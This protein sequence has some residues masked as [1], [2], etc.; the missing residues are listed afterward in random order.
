MPG[1]IIDWTYGDQEAWAFQVR[2]DRSHDATQIAPL[3]TEIFA[4]MNLMIFGGLDDGGWT[5]TTGPA[6]C[7]CPSF[8]GTGTN[9]YVIMGPG[10]GIPWSWCISSNNASFDSVSGTV[11]GVTGTSADV[12]AAFASSINAAAG[13]CLGPILSSAAPI[14]TP[15]FAGSLQIY[16]NGHTN[17]TLEVGPAGTPCGDSAMCAVILSDAPCSFNPTIQQVALTN[18]DCNENNIDDAV[19]IATGASADNNGNGI[20]DDCEVLCLADIDGSGVVDV[21]DLIAVISS[22]GPC[23]GCPADTNGDQVVDVLDLVAVITSWGQCH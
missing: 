18:E 16:M 3:G 13:A 11:A 20:P 1:S 9:S 14:G 17:F 23:S 7:I 22:W 15:P 12:A 19:D 21:S 4:G 6:P 2:S 8:A 10:I 5:V